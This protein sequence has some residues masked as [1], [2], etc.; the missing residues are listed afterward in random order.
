MSIESVA[1]DP[2]GSEFEFDGNVVV[3]GAGE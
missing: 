1:D 2:V 3:S